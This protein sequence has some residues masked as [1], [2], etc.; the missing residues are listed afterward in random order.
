MHHRLYVLLFDV[1]IMKLV[2]FVF[3]ESLFVQNH[4]GEYFQ[5]FI[6]LCN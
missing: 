2:F 5:F 1:K 4:F 6:G 3:S